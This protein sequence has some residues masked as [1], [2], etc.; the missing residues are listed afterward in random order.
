MNDMILD[1]AFEQPLK[2]AVKINFLQHE[3][4]NLE[5]NVR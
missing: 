3:K 4:D 2:L 1:D 5:E